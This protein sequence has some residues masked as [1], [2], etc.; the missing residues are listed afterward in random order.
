[1]RCA[2]VCDDHDGVHPSAETCSLFPG[3]RAE[4][5]F[6]GRDF[7]LRNPLMAKYDRNVRDEDLRK[8]EGRPALAS[9]FVDKQLE[10]M[11]ADKSPEDSYDA[12][13][14]WVI[15]NGRPLA[16]Q[17]HIPRREFDRLETDPVLR[18][19]PRQLFEGVMEQ[20]VQ[21]LKSKLHLRETAGEA[22][23]GLYQDYRSFQPA[24]TVRA[25][26]QRR[27]RPA[28]LAEE[29]ASRTPLGEGAR[30]EDL[31]ARWNRGRSAR[32]GSWEGP[33]RMQEDD[34]DAE[35][36]ATPQDKADPAER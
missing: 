14:A 30:P 21:L 8:L 2:A 1:M 32:L 29:K 28:R 34:S 6:C 11:A 17:M 23:T 35:P 4:F 25:L 36:A 20:Q 5:D 31:Q 19:P 13:R 10:E 15:E 7:E 27:V 24:S 26:Q 3:A 33:L 9:A 22:K 12:A 18:R 16:K